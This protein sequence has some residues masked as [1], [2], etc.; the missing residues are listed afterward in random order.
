MATVANQRRLLDDARMSVTWWGPDLFHAPQRASLVVWLALIVAVCALRIDPGNA[1]FG[2]DESELI[3]Y[4]LNAN[5]A[6]HLAEHGVLGT[7]G[8][9]YGPVPVWI[10]QLALHITHDPIKI[11]IM[12]AILVSIVTALSLLWISFTL[13]LNHWFIAAL[14]LSPFLW[15]YSRQLWDNS[16]NIPLCA[17]ATAA[18]VDFLNRRRSWSL[19]LAM[20]CPP[21][22]LMIHP[23]AAAFA[24]GLAAHMFI[25]ERQSLWRNRWRTGFMIVVGLAFIRPLLMDLWLIESA[26]QTHGPGLDGWWYA[27]TG[28][29]HLSGVGLGRFFTKPWHD[30]MPMAMSIT[31]RTAIAISTIAFALGWTGL[32]AAVVRWV[33][34]Q[35]HRE[36]PNLRDHAACLA[37][38]IIIA[39]LVLNGITKTWG[40]PQYFNATWIAFALLAWLALNRIAILRPNAA[41][42]VTA[43]YATSLAVIVIILNIHLRTTAGTRDIHHGPTLATQLQLAREIARYDPK[44]QVVTDLKFFHNARHAMPILLRLIPHAQ[45]PLAPAILKV[46]YATESPSNARLKLSPSQINNHGVQ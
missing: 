34:L 43:V 38:M 19:M 5:E 22:M 21:V 44:S 2:A 6:G 29:I 33:A 45:R 37:V 41:H 30:A 8:I 28:P 14:M 16:F 11:S 1:P 27:L 31:Y 39:Q 12:R 35:R 17:L 24:A 32:A 13:R 42:T 40:L 3:N 7:K 10:Y 46:E 26:S 18:Y 15:F 23:M 4:A 9:H 20:A 36:Q 25:F